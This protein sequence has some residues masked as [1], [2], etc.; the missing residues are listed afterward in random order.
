MNKLNI[1]YKAKNAHLIKSIALFNELCSLA[2]SIYAFLCFFSCSCTERKKLCCAYQEHLIACLL[3]VAFTR[4]D[5][6]GK[7]RS[8]F[9]MD[10]IC[11]W[12]GWPS[13][14][15]CLELFKVSRK[16]LKFCVTS[17][18]FMKFWWPPYKWP[19]GQKEQLWCRILSIMLNFWC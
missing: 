15:Y 18:I 16:I 3:H 2:H 19:L 6:G 14:R 13:A 1:D 9:L 11:E 17:W 7:G 12:L 4:R 5:L 8:H 10:V